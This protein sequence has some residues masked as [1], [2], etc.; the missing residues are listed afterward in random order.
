MNSSP[1]DGRKRDERRLMIEAVIDSSVVLAAI[2][3]E[4]GGEKAAAVLAPSLLSTVNLSEVVAKLA[5]RGSSWSQIEPI[6]NGLTCRI[7]DFTQAQAEVAGM[8]RFTTMKAG[9][10][11]G[12]RAC[13]ALAIQSRLPVWTADRAWSGLELGVDVRLIR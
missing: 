8:L 5:G 1:S 9:L 2:Y 6:V 3:G 11:F 7:V 4:P 10:S 13:L 12:E